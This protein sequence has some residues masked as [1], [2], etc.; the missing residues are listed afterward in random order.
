MAPIRRHSIRDVLAEVA[1][2]GKHLP[3]PSGRFTT[4][5]KATFAQESF[6]SQ[7]WDTV[8]REGLDFEDLLM[9]STHELPDV[10]KWSID[11]EFLTWVRVPAVANMESQL[12]ALVGQSFSALSEVLS[13]VDPKFN[14]PKV[15]AARLILEAAKILD[16]KKETV[17]K[18]EKIA[19]ASKEELKDIIRKHQRVLLAEA[20]TEKE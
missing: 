19:R 4:Q 2:T 15:S 5:F 3:R 12:K 16:R 6:K 18:D 1:D 8:A 7:I 10:R 9:A 20:E 14:G 11:Q 13:E 17:V